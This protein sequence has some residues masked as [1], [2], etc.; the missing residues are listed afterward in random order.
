MMAPGM[1]K[2]PAATITDQLDRARW[3]RTGDQHVARGWRLEWI[4]VIVNVNQRAGGSRDS[5]RERPHHREAG[6][7]EVL[8]KLP[9][10]RIVAAEVG[11]PV[12][13]SV[14]LIHHHRAVLASMPGEIAL[15]V[16]FHIQA[17]D[18]NPA[19]SDSTPPPVIS[20]RDIGRR[21]T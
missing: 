9:E 17:M 2:G 10:R 18:R 6:Y 16:P 8:A 12:A 1:N 20:E 11:L 7:C 13:I 4:R 5:W 14:H 19:R 21:R 3:S 15:S